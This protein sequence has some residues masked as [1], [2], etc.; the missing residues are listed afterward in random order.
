MFDGKEYF[1]EAGYGFLRVTP[2][3]CIFHSTTFGINILQRAHEKNAVAAI[4]RAVHEFFK[5]GKIFFC[6]IQNGI[7]GRHVHPLH[8]PGSV[9]N[10]G[11]P[12]SPGDGG[13]EKARDFYVFFFC[14]EMG[15][16]NGIALDEGWAIVKLTLL[17]EEFFK[18]FTRHTLESTKKAGGIEV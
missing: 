15:D 3:K 10:N 13:R 18:L 1:T 4:E 11:G 6:C 17:L 16:G 2:A 12:L 8:Q 14:K 9:L 7:V 5:R